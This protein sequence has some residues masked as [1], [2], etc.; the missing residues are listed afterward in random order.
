MPDETGTQEQIQEWLSHADEYDY[1]DY[2]VEGAEPGTV[3]PQHLISTLVYQDG[4]EYEVDE[5]W[6]CVHF[7]RKRTPEDEEAPNPH[8]TCRRAIQERIWGVLPRLFEPFGDELPSILFDGENIHLFIGYPQEGVHDVLLRAGAEGTELWIPHSLLQTPYVC[9]ADTDHKA[10]PYYRKR[11]ATRFHIGGALVR[12]CVDRLTG[13]LYMSLPTAIQ[14]PE[15]RKQFVFWRAMTA[16]EW[17]SS[18]PDHEWR[19]IPRSA[20][21]PEPE[22]EALKAEGWECVRDPYCSQWY[23]HRRRVAAGP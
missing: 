20:P 10:V 21:P 6:Q 16:E 3:D 19:I 11:Y 22:T 8:D 12:V 7:R 13:I 5:E 15:V 14:Q 18:I 2:S 23:C 9:V 1:W 4:E 17:M